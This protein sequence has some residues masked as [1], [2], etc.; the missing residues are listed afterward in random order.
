MACPACPAWRPQVTTP[1]IAHGTSQGHFRFSDTLAGRVLFDL[2][3][4]LGTGHWGGLLSHRDQ[5]AGDLI[6]GPRH[7]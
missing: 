4:A 6:T 3:E 5:I 2:E 1:G 7:N